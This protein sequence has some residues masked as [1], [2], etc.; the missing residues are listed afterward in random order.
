M[1]NRTKIY[2]AGV[3]SGNQLKENKG[4]YGTI[5][6]KPG[7]EPLQVNGGYLNTTNNRM[8]LKAVI[9]ALKRVPKSKPVTVYSD[10]EYVV[11]GITERIN[12]WIIKGKIE[13]NED[14][15]MELYEL[16]NKFN[17]IEFIKVKGHNGDQYNEEADRLA[18]IACT[19]PNLPIDILKN[20]IVWSKWVIGNIFIAMNKKEP[21]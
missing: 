11:L 2:T 20:N 10:S 7:E 13:K 14:L 18:T 9:E 1:H 12:N 21:S 15:W 8:E 17:D 6:F 3:C 16:K 5:I 19:Y 4:G